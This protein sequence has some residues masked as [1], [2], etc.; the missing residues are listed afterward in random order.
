MYLVFLLMSFLIELKS[1]SLEED[2]EEDTEQTTM[3]PVIDQNEVFNVSNNLYTYDDAKA[4]CSNGCRT[5]SLRSSRRRHNNGAEWCN[6]GWSD[7]QMA[8][9][10]AKIYME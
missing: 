10:L 2:K 4:V 7:G 5:C 9:F 6:Y 8:L 1:F 3:I